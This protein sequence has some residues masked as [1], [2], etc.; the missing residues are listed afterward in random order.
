MY[1]S[2]HVRA[3]TKSPFG[4]H[5]DLRARCWPLLGTPNCLPRLH[6]YHYHWGT[7][8]PRSPDVPAIPRG[9]RHFQLVVPVRLVFHSPELSCSLP[10]LLPQP[11]RQKEE[12]G[13]TGLLLHHSSVAEQLGG[14]GQATYSYSLPQFL[15]LLNGD[16]KAY[17]IVKFK[18][19]AD[20]NQL[21]LIN[22]ISVTSL[23]TKCHLPPALKHSLTPAAKNNPP[24]PNSPPNFTAAVF[25]SWSHS[26]CIITNPPY[27]STTT[28][29]CAFWRWDPRLI[30][31]CILSNVLHIIKL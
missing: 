29:L 7:Q 28:R 25:G 30:H 8:C 1:S 10:A 21:T 6:F 24:S 19:E 22:L 26:N 20:D 27:V 13:W 16:N 4:P 18:W 9:R 23:Q 2:N 17:L 3:H 5:K 15:H 14:F 11:F 31:V 12:M